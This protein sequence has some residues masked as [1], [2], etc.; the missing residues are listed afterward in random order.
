[1]APRPSPGSVAIK[2]RI[3]L[4]CICFGMRASFETVEQE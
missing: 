1:M 2:R 4:G 3:L